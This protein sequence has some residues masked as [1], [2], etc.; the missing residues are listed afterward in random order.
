MAFLDNTGLEHLWAIIVGKLGQKVDRESGKGLS[1]NDYTTTE[2]DKLAGIAEEANKYTLPTASSTLGGVKTTS[3]VTSTSGLTATPIINGIPYYKDTT[4]TL[5]DLGGVPA[6]RTINGKALSTNITLSANDV[7]A[8]ASEHT[9]SYLPLTGG[10]ITGSTTLQGKVTVSNTLIAQRLGVYS[11]ND[12][13]SVD[14][15]GNSSTNT[16]V[17]LQ[18]GSDNNFGIYCY[19]KS[20]DGQSTRYYVGYRFPAP[21]TGLTANKTYFVYSQRNLIY[22]STQPSSPTTGTIWLKPV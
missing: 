6:S 20:L 12:Y 10:T 11:T 13:P 5:S 2:K 4:Y 21:T 14:L 18:A 9:H 1:T 3:T 8:A 19:D 15:K 16:S 17:M 7:G 22:S